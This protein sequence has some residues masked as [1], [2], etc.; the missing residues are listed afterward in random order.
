MWVGTAVGVFLLNKVTGELKRLELPI[1]VNYINALS[2]DTN[3]KL[4]IATNGS[5]LLVYDSKEDKFCH[6]ATAN[7]SLIS[8][9]IYSV[10]F[11]SDSIA[12]MSTEKGLSAFIPSKQT[13]RN[14]TKDQ[15]LMPSNFNP[16]QEFSDG[17]GI[18]FSGA[19]TGQ[20]SLIEK[21]IFRNARPL[22]W[23]S[24][25]LKSFIRV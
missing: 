11:T 20:W 12:I 22:A 2:Q 15:G 17:T 6:Y 16:V 5:G 13:F 14:W 10:L 9:N 8:N 18:W 4:Y 24:T 25:I 1:R 23:Y 19:P 21:L 3:G 7:S